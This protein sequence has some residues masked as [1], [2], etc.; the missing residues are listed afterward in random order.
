MTKIGRPTLSKLMPR[1]PK[2]PLSDPDDMT[3]WWQ[4]QKIPSSSE[5]HVHTNFC[6]TNMQKGIVYCEPEH[7]EGKSSGACL[8]QISILVLARQTLVWHQIHFYANV[9][10][11]VCKYSFTCRF[12]SKLIPTIKPPPIGADG[13]WASDLELQSSWAGVNHTLIVDPRTRRSTDSVL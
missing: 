8:G 3:R 7:T 5:W 9:D 6:T 4:M 1:L 11:C 10:T 13:A 12:H 2:L